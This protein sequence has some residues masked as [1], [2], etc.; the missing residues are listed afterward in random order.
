MKQKFK[1]SHF[2]DTSPIYYVLTTHF[3]PLKKF[4]HLNRLSIHFIS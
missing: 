4:Q 1:K 3:K 2:L